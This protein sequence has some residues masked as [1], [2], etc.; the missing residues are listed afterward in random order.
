MQIVFNRS[1]VDRSSK[2]NQPNGFLTIIDN[3]NNIIEQFL[4]DVNRVK[5]RF[6]YAADA[7]TRGL[8]FS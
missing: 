3:L 1:L 8:S 4:C 2:A 5:K 6:S 7:N